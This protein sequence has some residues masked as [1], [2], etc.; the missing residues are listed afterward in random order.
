MW[1]F[2][3][4]SSPKSFIG[5]F[6]GVGALLLFIGLSIGPS[7]DW[8]IYGNHQ[9]TNGVQGSYRSLGSYDHAYITSG[10]LST[11]SLGFVLIL[12]RTA[13]QKTI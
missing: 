11:V 9:T 1:N 6:V 7:L 13:A 8:Y 3:V 10:V 2:I 5:I 12:R 4:S